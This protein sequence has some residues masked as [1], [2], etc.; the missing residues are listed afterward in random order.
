MLVSA[1][2]LIRNAKTLDIF[3]QPVL[4]ES[5]N[6]PDRLLSAWGTKKE[7]HLGQLHYMGYI[8]LGSVLKK[9]DTLEMSAEC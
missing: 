8:V 6:L 7:W 5:A 1:S 2:L 9:Y 3:L 4:A